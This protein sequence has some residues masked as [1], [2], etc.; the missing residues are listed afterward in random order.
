MGNDSGSS[1]VG[2]E[3]TVGKWFGQEIRKLGCGWDVIDLDGACLCSFADKMVLDFN[4]LGAGMHD[5]I[6]HKADT[7]L[8]VTIEG[9]CRE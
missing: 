6:V 1:A 9:G 5:G 2:D 8:I 7:G 4:V 3:T